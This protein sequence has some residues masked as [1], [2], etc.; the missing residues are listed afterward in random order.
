MNPIGFSTGALALGDFKTALGYL[1]GKSFTAIELSALRVSELPILLREM[2][3]LNLE[4]FTYIAV[5]VPSHFDHAEELRI[6]QLLEDAEGNWQIV[7]HPDTIRNPEL[8]RRFGNRLV[9]ENM[10][11]R[12][13]DGRT[14]QEMHR[15][16]DLMPDAEF[17]FDLAHAQQCDTT[18][19]EAYLLVK[20][21]A[22]RLRQVH[23]SQLDSASHHYLLSEGSVRAFSEISWLIPD[24]IPYIIESRFRSAQ[25]CEPFTREE[26]DDELA[27]EAEKVRRIF[28]PA[29]SRVLSLRTA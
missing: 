10:D 14:A 4:H 16:F 5:H 20:T 15:W 29:V 11:R 9:L 26:I 17:C 7:L 27:S 13:A 1:E 22:E 19:T 12:K 28:S 21:F 18:M 23:I 3:T 25:S 6:I 8:W 24:D 2:P